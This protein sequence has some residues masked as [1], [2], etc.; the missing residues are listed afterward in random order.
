MAKSS[1]PRTGLI[2]EPTK[3]AASGGTHP[4]MPPP[5]LE[6]GAL[7]GAL[8]QP[9]MGPP[10]SGALT[11]QLTPAAGASTWGSQKVTGMW[12]INENKNSWV[13]L[14]NAG[15]VKLS[16]ASDPGISTMMML[17]ASAKETQTAFNYRQ[18]SDNMIHEIYVW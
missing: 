9:T 2:P 16:N 18:E 12:T 7:S 1:K 5:T 13:A 6:A 8:A 15:W 10:V 17:A 4:M 3:Q 11:I 14:T